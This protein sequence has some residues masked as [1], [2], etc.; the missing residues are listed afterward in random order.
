MHISAPVIDDALVRRLVAAQFPEWARLPLRAI[1]PGGWDN[2]TFRL[3]EQMVVRVPIEALYA[4]QVRKEHR[5]LP[6]LSPRLPLEIPTPVAI[7]QPGMAFHGSG[8][9]T[10]GSTA[11]RRRWSMLPIQSPSRRALRHF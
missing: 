5:W 3:G 1:E 7:G 2:K 8:R 4:V 11:S 6:R 9:S 10:G